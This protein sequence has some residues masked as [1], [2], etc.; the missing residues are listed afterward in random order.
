[1]N[2]TLLSVQSNLLGAWQH[3]PRPTFGGPVST[4]SALCYNKRI[5][6]HVCANAREVAESSIGPVI[7]GSLD[8]SFPHWPSTAS[9]GPFWDRGRAGRRWRKGGMGRREDGPVGGTA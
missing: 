2:T 8:K 1:M 4:V 9:A 7:A 6:R 3:N 5:I